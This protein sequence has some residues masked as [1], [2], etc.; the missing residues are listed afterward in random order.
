[1]KCLKKDRD[2]RFATV[3]Q[4][5]TEVQC[6]INADH[7]FHDPN[8]FSVAE[9]KRLKPSMSHLYKTQPELDPEYVIYHPYKFIFKTLLGAFA[10]GLVLAMALCFLLKLL[11]WGA[12]STKAIL[13]I[14]YCTLISMF[15][16]TFLVNLLVKW[17]QIVKLL[18]K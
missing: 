11:S 9:R 1:M 18:K 16:I 13:T 6:H 7:L 2:L 5:V 4:L 15:T 14:F 8:E 3:Q 10:N 12:I 17:K